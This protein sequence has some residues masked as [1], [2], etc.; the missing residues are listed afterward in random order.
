MGSSFSLF[1]RV[2]AAL[3]TPVESLD[4][5]MTASLVSALY[6][7]TI[8]MVNTLSEEI[9]LQHFETKENH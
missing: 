1:N 7:R 4:D 6:K 5:L 9:K 8:S 3:T 2:I